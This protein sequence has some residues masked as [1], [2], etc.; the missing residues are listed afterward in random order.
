[1]Q[2]YRQYVF[3]F[4]DDKELNTIRKSI[5]PF[6]L[7]AGGTLRSSISDKI[8]SPFVNWTIMLNLLYCNCA[9]S[10]DD[11]L[12]PVRFL[13]PSPREY[14]DIKQTDTYIEF[15]L[16]EKGKLLDLFNKDK[17]DKFIGLITIKYF[18][19]EKKIKQ[20]RTWFLFIFENT[21]TM[22]M[23]LSS[24]DLRRDSITGVYDR[25]FIVNSHLKF[26]NKGSIFEKHNITHSE[27]SFFIQKAEQNSLNFYMIDPILDKEKKI[28]F[29]SK[30]NNLEKEPFLAD[31][32]FRK[33]NI[34]IN[35][36][37]V[38][39]HKYQPH[40]FRIDYNLSPTLFSGGSND[41]T[42][43]LN[44]LHFTLKLQTTNNEERLLKGHNN[45]SGYNFNEFINNTTLFMTITKHSVVNKTYTELYTISKYIYNYLLISYN[46]IF[47]Y[48]DININNNNNNNN[49]NITKYIP[50][51]NTFY[52]LNEI[53]INYKIFDLLNKN[54]Y[55]KNK[56]N[57]LC[58]GNNLSIIELLQFNNYKIKNITN[59]LISSQI[60]F[61]KN[62]NNFN[63]ILINL[64]KIYNIK[65]LLFDKSINDLIYYQN[66]NVYMK[67]ILV[68]YDIFISNRG[69]GKYEYYYN[70]GNLLI[71]ILMGLKYTALNGIFILYLGSVAY[72]HSADLY[73]IT[74]KYF[75]HSHLYYPENS[76][77]F[78]NNGVYA[79]FTDFNG[80]SNDEYEN[81]LN[82]VNKVNDIL[83]ND[84]RDFNIYN[85]T[86][87]H[88]DFTIY[89]P[90]D[91]NL[92]KRKHFYITGFLDTNINDPIYNVIRIFNEE[93]YLKKNIYITKL[94]NYIKIPTKELDNVKVPTPEQLTNAILYCK[95]YDIPYIDKF[96]N[97]AFQDKFGKKILHE[98]YG[99]HEPILYHFKTPFTLKI[100]SLPKSL[101]KSLSK[102]FYNKTKKTKKYKHHK[103]NIK[104]L[105]SF[106]FSN[107]FN[108]D[109][110]SS[111]SS[112]LKTRKTKVSSKLQNTKSLKQQYSNKVNLIPELDTINNR[113]EQTTKLIDSRRDFDAPNDSMQNL[114][115]FEAN[116]Q[117]RYYKHKDDKDKLHLDKKVQKL[118]GDFSISQAWLKM[119]EI[120]TDC[121]LIPTQRKGIYKSFHIC[122]APGTFINCINNYVF[123]KT[124][125]NTFDW[126]AQSLHTKNSNGKGTAFGDDYGLIRRHKERWDWGVDG[127]GDITKIM[128]IKH[129]EKVVKDMQ[130]VELITS[131]CGLPMKCDGYEKVA[132]A[133]LLTLL[134]ILPKGGSMVYKI[135][136]PIDEPTILNLIYLA[137]NNF[138]ELIFYK[139]VQNSQS[140]EFYIVGK[141]YLGTDATILDKFFDELKKF[142]E[143]EEIDLFN[144]MYP[145]A[146]VR[147]MIQVSTILADNFVYT[148]ERQIYFVDNKDT[149]SKEFS[150]LF[151]DYYNEK[152]E[153][154]IRKYKPMRLDLDKKFIL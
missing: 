20:Y 127:S 24:G 36:K 98:A 91:T 146:F 137:Y 136:T 133:S 141:G 73:I 3:G 23:N 151:Y 34:T 128:N 110:S 32:K 122:E 109:D 48:Q 145:E 107:L 105:S 147:Q 123:T 131:D 102:S 31:L 148:I 116:K 18:H 78:K 65:S 124:K 46:E 125:Y 134:H 11:I 138:K 142:K 115:W 120:I 92:E 104:R 4:Y 7:D 53:F 93:H 52:K 99:L 51:S 150:K 76:N 28:V 149:M 80:I 1:M 108:D 111:T 14:M 135:L 100:K 70:A 44:H 106:R 96:S 118:L 42:K 143:G 152:N 77:L 74:S 85:K 89:K 29:I 10:N 58:F 57:I 83:P 9:I 95:K 19:D 154:W 87:R 63:K 62:I 88:N 153:D 41:N 56:T 117:F 72:K 66:D 22:E 113:I 132:F 21:R 27:L 64:S 130:G 54:I 126:K 69:I 17:N 121:N 81:I 16:R 68:F 144:D 59:I 25:Y 129:Y 61:N 79:I 71:G 50:I 47:F 67:N 103:T 26:V 6:L 37:P 119:Y 112:S 101:S 13:I 2:K 60:N 94:L 90:I 5:R 15:I 33:V 139:P 43:Y 12:C 35:S 38:D 97:P 30:H 45:I 114:N 140:R 82:M 86:I 84:G 39:N 40:T 75:K 8:C 55:N 49:K